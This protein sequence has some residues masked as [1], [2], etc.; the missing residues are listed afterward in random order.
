MQLA[1][2]ISFTTILIYGF[3]L[4]YKHK[5]MPKFSVYLKMIILLQQSVKQKL[6][7]NFGVDQN[8]A[9]TQHFCLV[10]PETRE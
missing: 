9:F 8:F 6:Y 5:L 2:C 1:T 10:F 7:P 3:K 4:T